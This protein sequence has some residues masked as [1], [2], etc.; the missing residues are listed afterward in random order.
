MQKSLKV[1]F[2]LATAFGFTALLASQA[3]TSKV[4]IT[5]WQYAFDSKVK[6]VNTIMADFNKANPDIEV[7]QENFPYDGFIQK[8]E[9][10]LAAGTGPDVVNLFSVGFRNLRAMV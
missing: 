10:S 7:K 9:S 4:S 3:Q 6:I 2:F 1:G 5:Y 8:V